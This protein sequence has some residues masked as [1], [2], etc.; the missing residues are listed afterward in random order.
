MS[1][2]EFLKLCSLLLTGS[3]LPLEAKF[4]KTTMP[5]LF[6]G[7]GSP[8]N[9][10]LENSYTQ[11]LKQTATQI[12]KPSA[13]LIIS[14]HWVTGETLLSTVGDTQTIYDFGGFPESLY[15]V[16]YPTEGSKDLA[17]KLG[18]HTTSRGLDHGAWSVLTHMYPKANIPTMQLS[19]NSSL[20]LQE[21]F[22][23]GKRLSSLR[24][25]GVL[26]I[27]SGGI[28]HNL[29]YFNHTNID[30]KI[31][32]YALEFDSFIKH[33]IETNDFKILTTPEQSK[34]PLAKVHPTLEH[35]I[36]LL[37]IAGIASHRENHKFIYEGFQNAAFSM[38][39]W[40]IG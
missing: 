37:Y 26:I 4:S 9:I 23:L 7:H 20:S 32:P 24:K 27:G 30:A 1:R 5:A 38:R 2:Q 33:S 14:A 35:Y 13:I 3:L 6:F 39:A 21:H 31:E 8:M 29:M 28:T 11:M 36:P 10:I 18:M 25:H 16:S 40:Q 19:I 12:P 17:S 15:D 34:V 22:E